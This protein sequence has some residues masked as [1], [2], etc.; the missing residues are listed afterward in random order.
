MAAL[1]C[2]DRRLIVAISAALYTVIPNEQANWQ[3]A[4]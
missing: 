3:S 2:E 4:A 1:L